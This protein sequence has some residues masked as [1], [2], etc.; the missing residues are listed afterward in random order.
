MEPIDRDRV[1]GLIEICGRVCHA[2]EPK[3]DPAGFVRRIMDMGHLSVIEH[4][5]VGFM[6]TCSRACSHQLVRHRLCAISQ[7]S[8]RYCE[9]GGR[10][11]ASFYLPGIVDVG[12]GAADDKELLKN[13]YKYSYDLYRSLV[14]GGVRPQIA[15]L[16]LPNATMT[17]L[18]VTANLRQWLHMITLRTS[19]AAD[20]EIRA[21]F[22][23]IQSQFRGVLPEIF[24]EAL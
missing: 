5:S 4:V 6:V 21:L 18:A 3:G 2:S 17:R 23:D 10:K 1:I 11:E 12:F 22:L 14:M 8:Q 16:A 24:G 19:P 7:E 9:Y 13:N 20:E 15:R